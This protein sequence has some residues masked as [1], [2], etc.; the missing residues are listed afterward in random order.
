ME[1]QS[2]VPAPSNNYDFIMNPGQPQ[3]KRGLFAGAPGKDSFVTKILIL[4]GG[5]VLVM[6]VLAVVINLFFGGKTSLDTLVSLAQAEQEIVRLSA[7]GEDATSQEIKN[8]AV[9]TELSLTS[10]QQQWLAYL[11]ERSRPVPAEELNLKRNASLDAK[12]K[13]A[14]QTSTFDTTYTDI[15]RSQLT[16]YAQ[17]LRTAYQNESGAQK[18]ALMS[19]QYNDVVLLLKQWPQKTTP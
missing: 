11:A 7:E 13:T 19:N 16:T 2:G 15:M 8:A 14:A 5:A 4:V 3:P 6:I 12:L 17:A 1:P 9:T 10:H 18:R